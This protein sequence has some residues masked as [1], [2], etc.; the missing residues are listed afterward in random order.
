[1]NKKCTCK[2]VILFI[3]FTIVILTDFLLPV[4]FNPEDDFTKSA[5]EKHERFESI[6][7]LIIGMILIYPFSV[8][9]SSYTLIMIYSNNRKNYLSGDYLYDKNIN[10]NISLLMTVQIICGYSF[11]ILYCNIYLWRTLDSHGHYGKP[12]FYE[13]TFIP[14]YTIKQGITIFMIVKI[15]LIVGSMIGS[16]YF[17][18]IDLYKNDLGELNRSDSCSKYDNQNELNRL[19]QEKGLAVSFLYR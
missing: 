5:Q 6:G 9:L 4:A 15:I 13:T 14:D 3:A 11:S 7:A 18:S 17:T 10:D 16:Q 1:M 12:K 8:I 19:C 2:F